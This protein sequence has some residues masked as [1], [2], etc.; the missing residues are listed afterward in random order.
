VGPGWPWFGVGFLSLQPRSPNPAVAP[1]TRVVLQGV[2]RGVRGVVVQKRSSGTQWKRLRAIVP[3][4]ST[5]A[6]HFAVKPK[7]TTQYRLAT[8]ADA[9]ASVRIRVQTANVG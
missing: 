5:G 2:V 4:A 8:A 1:R 7:V 6:F 9:A 3:A